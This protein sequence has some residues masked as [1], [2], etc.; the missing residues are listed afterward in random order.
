MK[1]SIFILVILSSF[2][3]NAQMLYNELEAHNREPIKLVYSESEGNFF[4]NTEAI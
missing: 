3:L 2:T 1:Y 4:W